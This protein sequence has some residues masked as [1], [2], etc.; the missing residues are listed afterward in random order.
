[1]DLERFYLDY[2]A[3]SPLSQSVT[4]WLKSG[5]LL[6]ANPS[7]QHSLGKASRK[8]INE[9]RTEVFSTFNK[10]EADSKLFF[11]SGATE[12]FITIASSFAETARLTG[13]DLLICTSRTDHPC[14]SSL[15]ERYFGPHVKFLDI[16]K[17]KNLGSL[18][19]ETFEVLKDRKDNNPDLLILYHHLWVH[20]ETGLVSPLED[21]SILKNIPDLFIHVDAVQAI[22]KITNWQSLTNGDLWTFSAHKF[23]A[24]KGIGFTLMNKSLPFQALITGGGQQNGMRSGTENPQGAKSV[25]LA[26]SDIKKIDINKTSTLRE[27]LLRFM[28]DELNDLGKVLSPPIEFSNSNTIY[29]YLNHLTSDLALALFDLNGLDISA[30]SACSSGAA[31]ASEVL[32]HMGLNDVARNGLRL[33][34][35]FNLNSSELQKIKGQLKVIFGKLR[36]SSL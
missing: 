24:L 32:I 34:F 35:S 21:L 25:Q 33:S 20:N 29:F 5:D 2:N 27:E 3:T 26:L 10:S 19:T 1:V 15:S 31:K 6:F 11:H 17:A 14:V 8:V 28:E 4:D 9:A 30:G 12:A 23:G 7:S 22:G 16:K 13:R 36:T 18:H